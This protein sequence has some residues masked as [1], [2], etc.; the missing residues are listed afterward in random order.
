MSKN[1]KRQTV[2]YYYFVTTV[3]TIYNKTVDI[4]SLNQ[5]LFVVKYLSYV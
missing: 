5:M 4:N 2:V 3:S 1:E